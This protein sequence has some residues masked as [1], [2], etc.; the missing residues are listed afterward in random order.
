MEKESSEGVEEQQ[1][2][3]LTAELVKDLVD[4]LSNNS[5]EVRHGTISAIL[6]YTPTPEAKNMFKET[7]LMA[8]LRKYLFVPQLSK[9]CL[10]TLIHF[11]SE[12]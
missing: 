2:V 8:S 1:E 4:L 10:S 3:G 12:G 11:A 7:S 5:I 6:Q 9:I